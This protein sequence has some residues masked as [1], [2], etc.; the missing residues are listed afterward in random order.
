VI[1]SFYVR[2][3]RRIKMKKHSSPSGKTFLETS[4]YWDCCY[5]A[6]VECPDGKI[7]KVSVRTGSSNLIARLS[8][9][10]TTVTGEI[11][12]S[13]YPSC[14]DE[15]EYRFHPYGWLKNGKIFKEAV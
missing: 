2:E 1:H 6:A 8:Y 10:G 7:R 15:W 9:G 4:G 13:D 3:I 11:N 14:S 5:R 12:T